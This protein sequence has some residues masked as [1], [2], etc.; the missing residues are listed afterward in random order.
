[1]PFQTIKRMQFLA[2]FLGAWRRNIEKRIKIFVHTVIKWLLIKCPVAVVLSIEDSFAIR[3]IFERFWTAFTPSKRDM[4]QRSYPEGLWFCG[5]KI[6]SIIE[7]RTHKRPPNV[8]S[9]FGGARN[10]LALL[11]PKVVMPLSWFSY[12][13]R[14]STRKLYNIDDRKH[15]ETIIHCGCQK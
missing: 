14:T 13:Q 8:I 3:R 2:A 6:L 11:P 12:K 10:T 15:W 7:F 4:T 5:R 1:M 9:S